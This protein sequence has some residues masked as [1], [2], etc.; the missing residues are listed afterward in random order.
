MSQSACQS[1]LASLNQYA[2][3]SLNY[4]VLTA[5]GFNEPV[6]LADPSSTQLCGHRSSPG[7]RFWSW[8]YPPPNRGNSSGCV[9]VPL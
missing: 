8:L 4:A 2:R 9:T 5:V 1:R 7:E 6:D 3:E